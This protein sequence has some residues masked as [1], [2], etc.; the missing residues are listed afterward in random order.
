MSQLLPNRFTVRQVECGERHD[1]LGAAIDRPEHCKG[2]SRHVLDEPFATSDA[3]IK[4]PTYGRRAA[5]AASDPAYD[6]RAR[7]LTRSRG[8]FGVIDL[9]RLIVR[10][11][12][13]SAFMVCLGRLF[14]WLS[15]PYAPEPAHRLT[16]SIRPASYACHRTSAATEPHTTNAKLQARNDVCGVIVVFAPVQARSVRRSLW[17]LLIPMTQ[18]RRVRNSRGHL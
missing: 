18:G 7:E 15:L 9:I 5:G 3:L 6:G 16:L 14:R 8:S 2:H 17:T 11:T 10:P 13:L 12:P 1:A 4:A